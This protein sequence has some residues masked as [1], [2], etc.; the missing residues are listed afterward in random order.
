MT[1]DIESLIYT[2]IKIILIIKILKYQ[3]FLNE[4]T[5]IDSNSMKIIA[6][7]CNEILKSNGE[8]PEMEP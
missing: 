4:N 5:S 7:Y 6:D 8:E 3:S 1:Y 2:I